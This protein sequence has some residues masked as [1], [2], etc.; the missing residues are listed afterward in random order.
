MELILLNI[1]RE[2]G[3]ITPTLFTMLVLMAIGTTLMTTPLFGLVYRTGGRRTAHRRRRRRRTRRLTGCRSWSSAV[4]RRAATSRTAP[5]IDA[6]GERRVVTA[7][8]ARRATPAPRP[9]RSAAGH[10]P[11]PRGR[12][13]VGNRSGYFSLLLACL[14]VGAALLPIDG[15]TPVAE[16]RGGGR[17]AF[18]ASALV[19]PRSRERAGDARVAWR[20]AALAPPRPIRRTCSPSR[21]L[22][23]PV[24]L[25]KL[26]SGSTGLPKATVTTD[27]AA[28]R[29]RPRP[30]RGDGHPA[31]RQAARRDP[32][33]ALLRARQP[34]GAAVPAGHR[35]RAARLL[36]AGADPRRRASAPA[37][38]C[39]PACRSCSSS[40]RR[41][42]RRLAVAA[43]ARDADLG[44]RAARSRHGAGVR[45]SAPGANP[46]VLRHERDRRHL[47]TTPSPMPTAT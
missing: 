31:R 28:R 39:S 15:S 20:P 4:R 12:G 40:W 46:L 26:T 32:A 6:P 3:L 7:R 2:R 11:R 23:G 41:C 29:R 27:I 13:P 43:D 24:A 1:G 21:R 34:R 25:L 36:R 9:A 38:G 8:H 30:D 10:R 18:E 45:R 47:P 14:D 19:V 44:R 16:A 37:R 35:R 5:L 17:R 42:P 22:A 33:V